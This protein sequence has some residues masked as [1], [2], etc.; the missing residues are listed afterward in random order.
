MSKEEDKAK[1][2]KAKKET[3]ANEKKTQETGGHEHFITHCASILAD[4]VS[5]DDRKGKHKAAQYLLNNHHEHRA[6]FE[7]FQIYLEKFYTK[8]PQS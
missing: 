8:K 2:E 4:S 7:A 3:E 1:E 5:S 6:L